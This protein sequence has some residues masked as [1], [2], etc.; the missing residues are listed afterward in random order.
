MDINLLNRKGVH[1]KGENKFFDVDKNL[2]SDASMDFKKDFESTHKTKNINPNSGKKRIFVYCLLIACI[3]GASA[4]YQFSIKK[5]DFI[6]NNNI[7]SLFEFIVNDKSF[8][9]L[10]FKYANYSLSIKVELDSSQN[11][12]SSKL[13]LKNK[14]NSLI[15]SDSYSLEISNDGN[16]D[17]LSIYF[18]E[19]LEINTSNSAQHKHNHNHTNVDKV[20]SEADLIVIFKNHLKLCPIHDF[21]INK[22]E[23]DD[24]YNYTVLK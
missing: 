12:K 13:D 3:I 20:V 17:V 18:P 7:S 16:S 1:L 10:D 2:I 11:F 21:Q 6:D 8:N 22:F 15:D 24:L 9:L 5:K 19:F 4:Y 23:S 14:L